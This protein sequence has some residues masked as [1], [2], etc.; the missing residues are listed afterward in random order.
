[1]RLTFE[2]S[3][4]LAIIVCI[5]LLAYGNNK[6]S[7]NGVSL[8]PYTIALG[9]VNASTLIYADSWPST[10]LSNVL[11]ANTPQL[12]FS[13]L[14]FAFNSILTCM[15]VAAE[16]SSYANKRKSLRVSNNPQLA[17]RS[18]Y[19]LSIPYRYA[20]PL[21]VLSITLHWLISESL[22]MVGVEA[23][24]NDMQRDPSGDV[25]SCAYTP[26]AI[27][28]SILIGAFM[29]TSLVALSRQ[30]LESAMPVAGSCSLAI[31]A[32]CHPRVD[33]NQLRD[34]VMEDHRDEEEED[35]GL[36][37]VQWGA[38]PVEGPLGHSSFTS[39]DV[40]MPGNGKEY[41]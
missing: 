31:A 33:P 3:W 16:W 38:I 12:L 22:F 6:I 32:A 8:N 11:I 34:V 5:V 20:I 37:P 28:S 10:L 25:I 26:V 24:D 39:R 13:C 30:R 4:L 36:L 41:Q 35:M 17:Q 23:W 9:D 18:N 2:N 21:I 29:F 1:M 7:A 15:C 14:Y 40:D 27:L 19:F